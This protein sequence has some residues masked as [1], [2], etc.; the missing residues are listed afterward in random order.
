MNAEKILRYRSSEAELFKAYKV[1]PEEHIVL[2]KKLGIK[3]RVLTMG[4]GL[5]LLFIHGAPN[6]GSTWIQLAA[7]LPGYNCI[8]IDRPGCGLSDPIP[9]DIKSVD[10][11]KE[12]IVAVIDGVMDHFQ[13]KEISIA[14]SSMGGY[15]SMLYTLEK[16]EKVKKLILE[17]CP[18]LVE[19]MNIPTFMKWMIAPVLR[20]IVPNTPTSKSFLKKILIELGHGYSVYNELMPEVFVQ[21]YV[22]LFNMTHTQKNEIAL[23]SQLIQGG[24]ANARFILTDSEISNIIQPTLWLWGED[25]PFGGKE[26]GERIHH[27]MKN[28]RIIF[29]ENTG[30]LPWIDN[31]AIHANKITEFLMSDVNVSVK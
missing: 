13:L 6:A 12:I 2:I 31:P 4:Q 8:L 3:I 10:D 28:S 23:I 20:W 17:G 18:A 25:D 11:V 9:Y 27:K 16:K 21:W 15:L 26:I 7:L 30:H 5:P 29:F 14:A 1:N 19:D 24:K 22:C